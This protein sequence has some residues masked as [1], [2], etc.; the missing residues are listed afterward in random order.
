[1]K[2]RA[3]KSSGW[4][5]SEKAELIGNVWLYFGLRFF[6]IPPIDNKLYGFREYDKKKLLEIQLENYMDLGAWKS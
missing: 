3:T 1:M 5:Q 2:R 4:L 6:G